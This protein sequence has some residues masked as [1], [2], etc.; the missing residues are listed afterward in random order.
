MVAAGKLSGSPVYEVR[1][2]GAGSPADRGISDSL[3]AF[4]PSDVHSRWE[5]AVERRTEDPGGESLSPGRCSRMF[6]SGSCTRLA[7]PIKI[8]MTC[9]CYTRNWRR[10]YGLPPTTTRSRRSS[11]CW[12]A[13]SRSSSF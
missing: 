8:R 3:K 10:S 1:L 9:P 5:A 12:A 11:S 13:A 4:D 2:I 6:A 7:K